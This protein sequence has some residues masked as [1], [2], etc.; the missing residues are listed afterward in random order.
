MY[1][2]YKLCCVNFYCILSC[3]KNVYPRSFHQLVFCCFCYLNPVFENVESLHETGWTCPACR[4]LA[5]GYTFFVLRNVYLH[6]E[7]QNSSF[8][9]QK[10][11]S[12]RHMKY[13]RFFPVLSLFLWDTLHY[14]FMLDVTITVL[15]IEFT[16]FF[17][18]KSW[19]KC[20]I[21]LDASESCFLSS[22]LSYCVVTCQERTVFVLILDTSD[23]K[24]VTY[25]CFLTLFILRLL[26]TERK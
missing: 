10:K 11:Y 14:F 7:Q 19:F 22:W 5:A 2:F 4:H 20:E 12:S 3:T 1:V 23:K 16:F 21:M 17:Q 26:K 18:L 9:N 15:T 25:S 24:H 8:A 6:W 13:L